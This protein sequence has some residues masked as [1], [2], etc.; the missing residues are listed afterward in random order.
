MTLEL[1]YFINDGYGWECKR[2][3]ATPAA[4]DAQTLPRFFREG[5]AEDK[6]TRLAARAR[7]RWRD[8]AQ[9]ILYC[10]NCLTEE[11]VNKA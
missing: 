6:E 3:R 4:P 7:A 11:T 8:K 5:E 9:Q 10:P 2:C 1:D